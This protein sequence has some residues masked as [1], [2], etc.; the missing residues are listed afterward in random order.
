MLITVIGQTF[1]KNSKGYPDATDAHLLQFIIKAVDSARHDT[2]TLLSDHL[3]LQM[4]LNYYV[5]TLNHKQL[6]H[7]PTRYQHYSDYTDANIRSH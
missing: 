2:D 1:R 3:I 7:C 6:S 4:S 5:D